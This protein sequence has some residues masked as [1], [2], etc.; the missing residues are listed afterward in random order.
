MQLNGIAVGD[1]L[2]LPVKN[3]SLE[4]IDQYLNVL[5]QYD[6]DQLDNFTN[7]INSTNFGSFSDETVLSWMTFSALEHEDPVE[8]L[9]RLMMSIDVNGSDSTTEATIKSLKGRSYRAGYDVASNGVAIR[10]I[11]VGLMK[12]HEGIDVVID[13]VEKL[14]RITHDNDDAIASGIITAMAAS[15]AKSYKGLKIETDQFILSLRNSVHS[16]P[17]ALSALDFLGE[18]TFM[19]TTDALNMVERIDPPIERKSH[20]TSNGLSTTIWAVYS[21][22]TW[23]GDFVKATSLALCAGGDTDST[24]AITGGL[25]ESYGGD[26][27]AI[28]L[29]RVEPMISLIG[30]KSE[31][32]K[33]ANT[34]KKKTT[35]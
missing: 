1:A 29:Q 6:L 10:S 7:D 12:S 24:A 25:V 28:W 8:E 13:Y 32:N 11:P 9:K 33:K 15:A 27:P 17:N 5:F 3:K 22:L 20:I 26:I 31:E 35:K 16:Y 19:T 14:G 34:S 18:M 30:K 2:G 23:P 21:F 4:E